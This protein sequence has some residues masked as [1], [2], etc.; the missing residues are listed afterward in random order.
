MCISTNVGALPCCWAMYGDKWATLS[1]KHT[2]TGK[3]NIMKQSTCTVAGH[4]VIFGRYVC[5]LTENDGPICTAWNSRTWNCRTWKWRTQMTDKNDDRTRSCRTN[6]V[7]TVCKFFNPKHAPACAQVG[8]LSPL[9]LNL[10]HFSNRSRL[11][12]SNAKSTQSIQPQ[13]FA[14]SESVSYPALLSS[15]SSDTCSAPIYR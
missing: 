2:G 10:W 3:L 9:Y 8:K 4:C 7:L 15:S 14:A 6:R 13:T 12:R 1:L 5:G 11:Q